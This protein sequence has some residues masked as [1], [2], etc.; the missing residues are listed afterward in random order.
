MDNLKEHIENEKDIDIKPSGVKN[1]LHSREKRTILIY[2]LVFFAL[3]IVLS[4]CHIIFGARPLGIA[5]VSTLPIGAFPAAIGCL[6][7]SLTLGRGGILYALS[8]CFA[9]FLRIIIS[10]S[11]KHE[12][13]L[14]SETLILRICTSVI[15]GFVAALYEVLVSGLNQTTLMFGLSMIFIPPVL[16][17]IFSGIFSTGITLSNLIYDTGNIFSLSK[18][19]KREKNDIIFFQISALC[20]L[21]FVS[22]SMREYELFGISLAYIF[23]S[24]MTLLTA[25]RFGALRAMAVGFFSALGLSGIHA[26]GFALAGLGGGILFNFGVVLGISGAIASITAWSAYSLGLVGF[27]SIAPEFIIATTLATPILKNIFSE[28][29]SDE[30]RESELSASEM[31]GTMALCFRGRHT[32]NLDSLESSLASISSVIK[33]DSPS[34]STL[35]A[36]E[37]R[38][39]VID[40]ADRQCKNCKS[41]ALC[42]KQDIHPCKK[43]AASIAKKLKKGEKLFPEDI[44]T[45]VEFCAQAKE[46]C[47]E[48][49]SEAARAECELF[50]LNESAKSAEEYELISKLIS[51]A[52]IADDKDRALNSFLSERVSEAL[53]AGGYSDWVVRVFGERRKHFIAAGEDKDGTRILSDEFREIIESASE[54]RLST[55]EYF[56]KGEMTLME[57][58]SRHGFS[59]ECATATIAG[60]RSE[61]SGDT[62]SAFESDSGYFYALISDGMGRG[63]LAKKT[64]EFVLGFL[65][66]AL[67]FSASKETVLHLLNRSLRRGRDECSATVDL[68]ELDEYTGDAIFIKSGSAP[69]YIKREGSLFRI[70]SETAPIGLMNTIDTEKVRVEVRDGDMIIML[71]DGVSQT[72]DDAPWLLEFLARPIKKDSLKDYADR[73]IALARENS[74]SGDDM[75]VAVIKITKIT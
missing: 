34:R 13:E 36:E 25:K 32:E 15:S 8:V 39:I 46:L 26:T 33:R 23:V 68:F 30:A 63:E 6:L 5:Y 66:R 53:V 65:R 31:V 60:D 48:L 64:S 12:S 18:K 19:Q 42:E 45:D 57:C 49:E 37:Y 52:R 38:N 11:S 20:S 70:K 62:V 55:P 44:N 35:S 50:R 74:K 29:T 2:N 75:S 72:S 71:S 51:E 73:I 56:R 41:A 17:F 3:G 16:T 59:A 61:I 58:G 9:I 10:G 27:L 47:D 1:Y 14:F 28:R 43:N 24:L 69:S 7:G 22:L 54:S 21:F 4:R 67:N 40:I